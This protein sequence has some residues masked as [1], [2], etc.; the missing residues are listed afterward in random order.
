M[1]PPTEDWPTPLARRLAGSGPMPFRDYMAEA[2]Y[3]DEHGYY[4]QRDRPRLRRDTTTVETT[5]RIAQHLAETFVRF[6]EDH[7]GHLI[8]QGPGSGR[9]VRYILTTLP[10]WMHD[11]IEVTFIEPNLARRTR[12]LVLLQEFGVDGRVIA[13]PRN[14]DPGPAFAIA[15]ELIG[16][17][18]VHW[19]ERTDDGWKEIHVAFDEDRWAWNETLNDLPPSLGQMARTHAEPTP[20]GH[21][22]EANLQLRPWLASIADALD[23]GLLLVLDRPMPDPPDPEGS[24]LALHDGQPTTPYHAPGLVDISAG[25][26]EALLEEHAKTAGLQETTQEMGLDTLGNPNLATHVFKKPP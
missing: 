8:D 21:R 25:L 19:L 12:L 3:A 24:L 1:P 15:K 7:D 6:A 14:L 23:P 22:Y 16:S 26:D 10:T 9:L 2:L 13:S 17:F 5:R 11:E 4:T 18:P 20:A